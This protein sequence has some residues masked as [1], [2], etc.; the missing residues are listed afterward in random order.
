MC[1]KKMPLAGLFGQAVG[2]WVWWCTGHVWLVCCL[3]VGV[4]GWVGGWGTAV[5]ALVSVQ[6]LWV[7][8]VGMNECVGVSRGD[9]CRLRRWM[10][11]AVS[12]VAGHGLARCC[13]SDVRCGVAYVQ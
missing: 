2:K 8:G 5:C 3:S 6:G 1:E 7:W 12:N 11:Q 10:C 13:V 9:W 4:G